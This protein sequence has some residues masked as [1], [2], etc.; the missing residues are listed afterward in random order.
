CSVNLLLHNL[1]KAEDWQEFAQVRW[2]ACVRSR[3]HV[4]AG[5][6]TEPC[7]Y[8]SCRR[9]VYPRVTSDGCLCIEGM[10]WVEVGCCFDEC[11]GVLLEPV[12]C[13][14][15]TLGYEVADGGVGCCAFSPEES[16]LE[17]F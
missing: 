11:L 2:C 16:I 17:G 5:I 13:I 4:D 10:V 14:L 15:H 8:T 12:P 6:H 1:G 3:M 7:E 9:E